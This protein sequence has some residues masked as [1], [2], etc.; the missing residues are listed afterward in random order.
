[1]DQAGRHGAG[2]LRE[3]LREQAGLDLAALIPADGGESATVFLATGQDGTLSVLK[4][5]LGAT[6]ES[7]A[8]MR[9]LAERLRHRG[10][11]AARVLASGQVAGLTFWLQERLPGK[12]I[13]QV[14]DWL[15][16]EV[17]RLNN[18]QAG[19]GDGTSQLTGMLAATLT[20]G[21]DGFCVHA[22]LEAR[23]DTR[24]LLDVVRQTA[25]RHL[26]AVPGKGDFV[27]GDF[28]LANL[29]T[30]GAGITGVI[31]INPPPLTGDR[32]FDLATLLFYLYDRDP[33]REWLHARALEITGQRA[34]D[35]Y[36]AHMMLR[37]VDWSLRYHPGTPALAHHLHLARLVASDLTARP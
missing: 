24:A 27:H 26:A 32:A 36:L 4:V 1:M 25:A 3:A 20:T 7:I 33:V 6:S 13:G 8:R 2:E 10:Y 18:A 17:L 21:G 22:T 30:S 31:D 9:E 12:V 5:S 35:V 14:P 16:P 29:L 34:L 23:P 19:L 11:P 37:Q 28:T 15:L